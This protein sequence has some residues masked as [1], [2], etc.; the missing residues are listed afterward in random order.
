[1]DTIAIRA[2]PAFTIKPRKSLSLSALSLSRNQFSYTNNNNNNNNSRN[3]QKLVKV[4]SRGSSRD[5]VAFDESAYEAER[6]RLDA[7]A[8]NSMAE[9]SERDR[10]P[11]RPE[12]LE[13]GDPKAGLGSD[14]GPEHSPVPSARSPSYSQLRWIASRC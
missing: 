13:M 5:D 11:C 8:R 10:R 3:S 6:L 9:T 1:M 2:S 7:K 4:E 14:G 12:S